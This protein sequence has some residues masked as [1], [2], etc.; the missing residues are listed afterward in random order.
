MP[1]LFCTVMYKEI[2][3]SVTVF[4]KKICAIYF[5]VAF[6]PSI[7]QSAFPHVQKTQE[8]R[9]KQVYN[10]LLAALPVMWFMCLTVRCFFLIRTNCGS[11]LLWINQNAIWA[12]D[13]FVSISLENRFSA[14]FLS[15]KYGN[16]LT[17]CTQKRRRL[18]NNV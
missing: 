1:Y 15:F 12:T 17:N 7:S 13:M 3:L 9:W 16:N 8:N 4:Q 11:L 6:M 5:I 18:H 14:T 2:V 10:F